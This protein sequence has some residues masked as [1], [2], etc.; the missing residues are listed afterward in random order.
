MPQMLWLTQSSDQLSGD[1]EKRDGAPDDAAPV[2]TAARTRSFAAP[3]LGADMSGR[4]PEGASR[5]GEDLG[6][7]ATVGTAGHIAGW[8]GGGD[9]ARAAGGAPPPSGF[10][11]NLATGQNAAGV[12]QTL[13]D[14][15][16][17]L[18]TVSNADNYKNGPIAYTVAPGDADWWTG[19]FADGPNS[20]WI[21]ADPD[22]S[23]NGKVT[24]TVTF[25][26]TG[27]DPAAAAL[28]G[29]QFAVDDQG[30]IALNG[31]VLASAPDHAFVAFTAVPSGAG[32]FVAGLN[33]ITIVTT[34]SDDFLEGARFEGTVVDSAIPALTISAPASAAVSQG[35]ATAIG[36]VSLATA[37]GNGADNFTAT[38]VDTGGL[39]SATG[40]GVSGSGT[41]KLTITGSLD[42]VNSD[43]ATVEDLEGVTGSD[44]VTLNARDD[45]GDKAAPASIALTVDGP[46]I[47]APTAV[48]VAAGEAT[49]VSGVMLSLSGEATQGETYTVTLTDTSGLLAATGTGVSGS[50]TNALVISG[51]LAKVNAALATLTDTAGA[52]GSDT[53]E[54]S[55]KD[56]LGEIAVG[57]G[58]TVTANGP[59][60][61]SAPSTLTVGQGH[62]TAIAGVSLAE[63]G[64]TGSET[65]TAVLTDADGLLSATGSGISGSGTTHLTI[66]GSLAQ[67]NADLATLTDNA[68]SAGADTIT[69]SASDS[70]GG[71]AAPATIGVTANGPPAV[72]APSRLTTSPDRR[73]PSRAWNCRNPATPPAKPS[74]SRSPTPPACS[75]RPARVSR[76]RERRA[77]RSPARWTR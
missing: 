76:V 54:I 55:A 64:D 38:L 42:Q 9:F 45:Q 22:N 61:I 11:L 44:T 31:H 34:A 28:V 70:L 58:V 41:N 12:I 32:D 62:A 35:H 52:S 69:I 53:I 13:G 75:R 16:D 73:R 6:A 72:T 47:A 48:T 21:A 59:P 67:V 14:L 25:N 24:Y 46:A 2:E 37:Q 26:L 56:S 29:A 3:K 40:A 63:A 30:Y 51:A 33:T 66:A 68:R 10:S 5:T 27:Y 1:V 19:W 20:T 74:R 60:A 4:P 23:D 36:G 65:F 71:E 15:P 17:A 77:S 7:A 43:L 8:V 39:L 49:S 50:G 18:W 57:V